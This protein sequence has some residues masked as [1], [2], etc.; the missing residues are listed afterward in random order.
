[1]A[2]R[3]VDLLGRA[4]AEL[5]VQPDGSILVELGPWE[6]RTIQLQPAPS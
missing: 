2:A 6:I 3:E 1:M 4:G 5:P